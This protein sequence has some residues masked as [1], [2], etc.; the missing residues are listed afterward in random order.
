MF[1]NVKLEK[2]DDLLS[3]LDGTRIFACK[4]FECMENRQGKC[5]LKQV[6]IIANQ[7]C[8]SYLEKK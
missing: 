8:D 6:V 4:N 1:D 7:K 5:G 3:F 2:I